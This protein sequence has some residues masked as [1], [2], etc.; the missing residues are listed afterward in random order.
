[1]EV[2]LH[3]TLR[4]S[5]FSGPSRAGHRSST[6][7]W[8]VYLVQSLRVWSLPGS[9]SDRPTQVRVSP[10]PLSTHGRT[11]GWVMLSQPA[12][13]VGQDFRDTGPRCQGRFGDSTDGMRVQA[14]A[15]VCPSW[16]CVALGAH[17][18]W[19]RACPSG[20]VFPRI[21]SGSLCLSHLGMQARK[22]QWNSSG[23]KRRPAG[24]PVLRGRGAWVGVIGARGCGAACSLCP[25]R[26]SP[27]A[28]CVGPLC[29]S[30]DLGASTA[31]RASEVPGQEGENQTELAA[32][33]QPRGPETA[34]W[35]PRATW[36]PWRG[37][38]TGCFL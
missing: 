30:Q 26:G 11:W 2:L 28:N 23:A 12:G 31:R 3:S 14:W 32:P 19:E 7:L 33:G 36:R 16:P 22:E 18:A 1:M 25:A 37:S 21:R 20:H 5:C 8:P 24:A 13:L 38:W 34:A 35:Q 9:S 6:L 10:N 15:H 17:G 29:L 27:Q 4:A